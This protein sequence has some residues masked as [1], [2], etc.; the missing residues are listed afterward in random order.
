MLV[1]YSV[2]NGFVCFEESG[3]VTLMPPKSSQITCQM[4]FPKIM[5]LVIGSIVSRPEN[6]CLVIIKIK[7]ETS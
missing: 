6:I 1:P 2:C 5:F 4:L 7:Q 3:Q